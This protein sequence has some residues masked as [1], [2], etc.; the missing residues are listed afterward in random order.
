MAEISEKFREKDGE[1]YL[2]AS[3]SAEESASAT[4]LS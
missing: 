1:I 2:S 4:S 3:G